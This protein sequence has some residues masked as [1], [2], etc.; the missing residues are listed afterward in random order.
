MKGRDG[1]NPPLSAKQSAI[2]ALSVEKSKILRTFVH[3]L[4][5]E[6]TGEARG[7]A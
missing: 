7:A 5:P 2:S 6:G 3:F 4:L 1:S